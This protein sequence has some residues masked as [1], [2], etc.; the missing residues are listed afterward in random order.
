MSNKYRV[1]T[2]TWYSDGLNVNNYYFE[3]GREAMDFSYNTPWH[4]LKVY[5]NKDVLMH[6]NKS[7]YDT[8]A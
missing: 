5:D 2:Y 4:V 8:Y 7:S 6:Q 3:T 1:E